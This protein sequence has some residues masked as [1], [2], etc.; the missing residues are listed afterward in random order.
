MVKLEH[1]LLSKRLNWS[2]DM[3][4]G[5]SIKCVDTLHAASVPISLSAG[6]SSAEHDAATRLQG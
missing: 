5:P 6:R 3:V 4:Q 1:H 2:H